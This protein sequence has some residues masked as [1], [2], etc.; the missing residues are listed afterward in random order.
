MHRSLIHSL[1]R[2]SFPGVYTPC[3]QRPQPYPFPSNNECQRGVKRRMD[4]RRTI[5][6]MLNSQKD[7][8]RA[9]HNA[10]NPKL[11]NQ[12]SGPLYFLPRPSD[13]RQCRKG[14]WSSCW[15]GRRDVV[16]R[17][18]RGSDGENNKKKHSETRSL[19][20]TSHV[21]VAHAVPNLIFLYPVIFLHQLVRVGGGSTYVEL[22]RLW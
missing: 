17:S 1:T 14:W 8:L 13:K 15:F 10:Q 20:S 22:R 9:L 12:T 2:R 4:Y 16:R 19:S 5:H 3:R 11:S 7:A 6:P 18:C 21:S